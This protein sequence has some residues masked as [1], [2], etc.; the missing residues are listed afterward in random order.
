LTSGERHEEF[1]ADAEA[2]H[3]GTDY[4]GLAKLWKRRGQFTAEPQSTQSTTTAFN[5]QD[6]KSTK[7]GIGL[8]RGGAQGRL[9]E[10]AAR[11]PSCA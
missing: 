1:W 10:R 8:D 9:A 5:H 2:L 7:N 3:D 4:A 11:V 6:T